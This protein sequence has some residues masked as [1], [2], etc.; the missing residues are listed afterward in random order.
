MMH[1]DYIFYDFFFFFA[2]LLIM[3]SATKVAT[4]ATPTTS[5]T[6]GTINAHSRSGKYA[7]SGWSSSTNGCDPSAQS[8][9]REQ[10]LGHEGWPTRTHRHEHPQRVVEEH[11]RADGQQARADRL[12]CHRL[13]DTAHTK[14]PLA[15]SGFSEGQCRGRHVAQR[16][17]GSSGRMNPEQPFTGRFCSSALA[18]GYNN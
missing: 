10:R 18:G 6:D 2:A 3:T 8:V 7:C 5:N 16:H 17:H 13:G 14:R 11:A 1:G 15:G 4:T 12:V 9:E